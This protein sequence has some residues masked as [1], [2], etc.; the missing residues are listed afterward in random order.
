MHCAGGDPAT[1]VSA[2]QRHQAADGLS[3]AHPRLFLR[4]ERGREK[5]AKFSRH[6]PRPSLLL[7]CTPSLPLPTQGYYIR[8]YKIVGGLVFRPAVPNKEPGMCYLR[9]TLH[10]TAA[11]SRVYPEY[12]ILWKQAYGR[13]K[14][15]CGAHTTIIYSPII[16]TTTTAS[17]H[18]E[19]R[20]RGGGG[21]TRKAPSAMCGSFYWE[22]RRGVAVGLSLNVPSSSI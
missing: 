9:R 18:R 22:D 12:I 17:P 11:V 15:G 5:E 13:W 21:L 19:P 10:I 3:K 2:T 4:S 6:G 7:M 8:T 14:H 16:H 1:A 20:K